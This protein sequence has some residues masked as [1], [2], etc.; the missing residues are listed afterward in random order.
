MS[1]KKY[2]LFAFLVVAL[3][4]SGIAQV[5]DWGWD[6]KDSSKIPAKRMPQQNEFLNNNYPYPAKPR[7]QWELGFGAGMSRIIGDVKSKFGFGGS[8]SA[9]KAL[10]HVISL[11]GEY[12]GSFN[13]GAPTSKYDATIGQKS[14]KTQTHNLGLDVIASLNT[15]G[16]Y[17][18]N[19]KFNF[20]ILGG[21]SLVA[22]Q[23]KVDYG[24]TTGERIFYGIGE[25]NDQRGIIT[26]VAGVTVNNRKGWSV[27]PTVNLGAGI[28]YKIDKKINIGL[29][30][31]VFITSPGYDY[32]DGFKFGNS[33]DYYSYTSLRLNINIGK[34]SKRVEPLFWINPNNYI[35]NEVNKPQ[36]MKMP[37][38][39]LDD[40]DG[41]GVTDQFDLEPNTPAGA[42][43]DTHG[44]ALDTDGDGVP[45]FRDKEML[46]SQKC[47][48]VNNEGVGT[49][50]EPSCCKEMRDEVSKLKEDIASK[51]VKANDCTIGDLPSVQF[52]GKGNKLD[53]NAQD[54]LASIAQKMAANP[55]SK[56]KV[57]GYG[58]TDKK[59]QQASWERVNAVI[60]YLVEKQGVAENRFVF[61]Y[62]QDG[63][64]NTV[65]L[66]CTTEEGPNVV[67]APHPN[68][69]GK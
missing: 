41:D 26:T 7:D 31:K 67:P 27:M 40:K 56:I 36:H 44:R 58:A 64:A 24:G 35:Y 4:T 25:N 13:S 19:P 38:V 10:G 3:Q 33:N 63:D 1:T 21:A 17:R 14:Y 60:N 46:T 69:K 28:A 2:L 12:I 18:G 5:N 48:P 6:W 62:G 53:K 23:V 55:T 29:E 42:K 49:C 47:F 43:V 54:L 15:L 45:D 50:P 30:N 32:A 65:D 16:F 20:Y 66:Q 52:K 11:R 57:I 22:T 9:R 68:L 61:T 8:I 59:A 39:K 37:K 34:S 51:L